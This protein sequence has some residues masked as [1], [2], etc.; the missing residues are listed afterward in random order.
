LRRAWVAVVGFGNVGKALVAS[1][2]RSGSLELASVSSS[3]GSVVVRGR[4]DAQELARIASG[5]AGLDSHSGFEGLGPVEA[6]VEAGA[7]IALVAI[8]PSYETGEPNRGIYRGLVDN[9][10]DLVTAD[11]TVLALEYK[12]FMSYA[13]SRGARVAYSATVAAGT[14]VLDVARRLRHRRVR[15]V[16]G[17]LNATTNL[18]ISMVES[19][20]TWSQALGEAVRRSLVEPDPRIDTHGWDAAAKLAILL[21]VLGQDASLRDVEREPLTEGVD[22]EEVREAAGKGR[23]LRYVA[24]ADLARGDY[25]VH[26]VVLDAGDPLS[27]VAGPRNCVVFEVEDDHVVVEGPAGPAWRTA[28]VMLSDAVEI[29]EE[30]YRPHL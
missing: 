2:A 25:R 14:P 22:E 18:L 5:P 16:R 24:E 27:R 21:S 7:S 15:R 19:G 12:P 23:R 4:L 17:V 3:R 13:E 20:S 29:L 9:G 1:I 8:P 10:L 26:P 11:K 30:R 28:E 6:A